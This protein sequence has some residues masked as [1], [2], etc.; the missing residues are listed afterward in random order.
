MKSKEKK[1]GPKI[2]WVGPF[3]PSNYFKNWLAASPAAFKW[4]KHI[5]QALVEEGVDME[6]L[7]YRPDPY[8]P[9]GRLLPS[10]VK[11]PSKIVHEENQI[12][13]VNTIFLRNFTLKKSLQEILKKK[14]ENKNSQRLI[15]IS[16]NCPK[17]TNKIFLDQ[18]IRSKFSCIYVVADEEVLPGADG[19][20]FLSYGSFKKYSKKNNKIH[21]DGAIY[22]SKSLQNLKNSHKKKNKTIFLYSGSF[23]KWGGVKILLDAMDLI[24]EDKFELW[25][26]GPAKDKLFKVAVKKDKR[27]K[28]LGLLSVSQLQ[29]TFNKADIFLN[30][31]PVNMPGNEINFPSK[32]FDYLAWNKPILST[33]TKSLSPIY[34]KVLHVVNDNPAAFASAMISFLKDKKYQKINNKKWIKNKNWNNEARKLKNLLKK[35]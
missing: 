34:K 4:Q 21:L 33:W 16:Y 29:N 7:Y 10:K 22:P 31:R 15:I 24:K 26:C 27:I 17:W 18:N 8:W 32:L 11:I 14:I 9:K 35:L 25:I 30:P 2:L 20:V 1:I 13:Y 23:D 5:F 3:I 28:Y 6:W 19:Y 12:H